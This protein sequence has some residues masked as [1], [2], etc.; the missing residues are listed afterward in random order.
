MLSVHQGT[1]NQ[2]GLAWLNVTQGVVHL[3]ECL[4]DDLAAWVLRIGAGELI[5]SAGATPV[6]YTHL[7]DGFFELGLQPWDVAA[8][9]LLITEAGG[10]VG[11]LSG[12]ANFLEQHECLA[13]NPRIYVQLVAVL[14]KNSKFAS[15]GEKSTVRAAVAEL[16]LPKSPAEPAPSEPDDSSTL[17]D[18]PF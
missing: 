9:S 10:L 13:A 1:R 8:G 12:D 2:C 7:T 11:N 14:G 5:F 18:A 15:A 3:A 4:A 17:P 6:S 16:A